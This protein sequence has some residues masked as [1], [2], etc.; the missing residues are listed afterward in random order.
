MIE[1]I[2]M[3]ITIV[4]IFIFTFFV[5]RDNEIVRSTVATSNG[6]KTFVIQH[7]TNTNKY[8]I[9]ACLEGPESGVY[10]RGKTFITKNRRTVDGCLKPFSQNN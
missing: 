4:I 9:H 3:I 6:N 10:Y 5:F 8:L 2:F 7:P 1:I